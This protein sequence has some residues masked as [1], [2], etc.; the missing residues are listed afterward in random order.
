VSLQIE[1]AA[2]NSGRVRCNYPKLNDP[3]EYRATQWAIWVTNNGSTPDPTT[4]PTATETINPAEPV[5]FLDWNTG[6]QGN[7]N[8]IKVLVR[9]RRFDKDLATVDSAN[10]TDVS[11]TATSTGP[12]APV[13]VAMLAEARKQVQ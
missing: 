2:T 6:D 7:G 9:T 10:T 3:P 8:T 13:P 12:S 4:T 1:A 5:A 11:C